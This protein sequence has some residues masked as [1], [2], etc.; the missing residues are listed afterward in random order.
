MSIL[1]S[2]PHMRARTHVHTVHT[3][4]AVLHVARRQLAFLGYASHH[5]L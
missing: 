2:K 5:V 4:A 1:A 3:H